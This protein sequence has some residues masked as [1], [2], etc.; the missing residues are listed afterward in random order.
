[1]IS[2]DDARAG[3]RAAG[4]DPDAVTGELPVG[5]RQRVEILKVLYRKADI[6]ILDEPT[7]V[8][9]P[10]ESENLFQTM[11]ALAES[12]KSVEGQNGNTEVE[13]TVQ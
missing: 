1:M 13:Q 5:V 9:T 6:L 11:A 12:G 7:A 4:L 2:Q 8:L 10:D 3:L